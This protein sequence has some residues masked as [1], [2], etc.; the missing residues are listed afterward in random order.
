[1]GSAGK[2]GGNPPKMVA[3]FSAAIERAYSLDPKPADTQADFDRWYPKFAKDEYDTAMRIIMGV[4]DAQL[5]DELLDVYLK[6]FFKYAANLHN[7]HFA[8]SDQMLFELFDR[9]TKVSTKKRDLLGEW[10]ARLDD[11]NPN[12]L[13][14]RFRDLSP[15]YQSKIRALIPKPPKPVKTLL[16]LLRDEFNKQ[17]GYVPKDNADLYDF[18]PF[19]GDA[20]KN[21]LEGMLGAVRQGWKACLAGNEDIPRNVLHG[22]LDGYVTYLQTLA[23]RNVLQLFQVIK[24]LQDGIFSKRVTVDRSD[25]RGVETHTKVGD[26]D[27]LSCELYALACLQ[28]LNFAQGELVLPTNRDTF[29]PEEQ[30]YFLFPLLDP[31]YEYY[32]NIADRFSRSLG[33]VAAMFGLSK[34]FLDLVLL[35]RVQIEG[36]KLVPLGP[37][38]EIQA[39]LKSFVDLAEKLQAATPT[40]LDRLYT[41]KGNQAIAREMASLLAIEVPIGGHALNEGYARIG[42]SPGNHKLLG[43]ITIIHID[44]KRTDDFYVEY[45]AIKPNLFLVNTNYITNKLFASRIYEIHKSTIG[46]VYVVSGMFIMMGFLPAFIEG[47][48]AALVH[49][50]AIAYVASKVEGQAEKINPLFGKLLGFALQMM[51]P[52]KQRFG[53]EVVAPEPPPRFKLTAFE[54]KAGPTF[55]QRGARQI[56]ADWLRG[57][58]EGNESRLGVRPEP[59]PK[60]AAPE[61]AAPKPAPSGPPPKPEPPR[62]EPRQPAL[63]EPPYGPPARGEPPRQ[64][65]KHQQMQ[66]QQTKI[67]PATPE[68]KSA[69]AGDAPSAKSATPAETTAKGTD[70]SAKATEPN[71]KG[72][73]ASSTQ[74][75]N[76]TV[77]DR[78]IPNRRIDRPLVE[79]SQA[80]VGSRP[81]AKRSEA[82]VVDHLGD[83][84]AVE[85]GFL[86]GKPLRTGARPRMSTHPEAYFRYNAKRGISVEVKNY[87]IHTNYRNMIND[88]I[89]QGGGRVISSPG[90]TRGIRWLFI[91]LRGQRVDNL[92]ELAERIYQ[93]VGNGTV[94]QE[95]YFILDS[96]IRRAI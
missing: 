90:H 62:P 47:G 38:H 2:E 72:T 64:N 36:A 1:M 4:N 59:A 95:L 19:P 85:P 27:P 58:P 5:L 33:D 71:T 32:S 78:G 55:E 6:L 83:G 42:A 44:P 29:T 54:V 87:D 84:W 67:P 15:T 65:Y 82:D 86:H 9:S 76:Q 18:D 75:S 92:A 17:H 61:P 63:R 10:G 94:Y 28:L 34:T 79:G 23:R 35:T 68:P 96:G 52:R 89:E 14:K 80:K 16:G 40:E 49:E 20:L 3:S 50:I 81:P 74:G 69:T 24:Y 66:Q 13:Q 57:V 56:D 88:I 46:I 41:D 12:P 7:V 73:D 77:Q 30:K 43:A 70:A 26:R 25:G 51:A 60:S 31:A 45:E 22:L 21:G 37:T 53:V 93:D 39:R 11:K 8:R 48:F 91:E